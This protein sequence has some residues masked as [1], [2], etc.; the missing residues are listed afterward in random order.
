MRWF[1]FVVSWKR[2]MTRTNWEQRERERERERETW[3]NQ[4]GCHLADLLIW[5]H[6]DQWRRKK[7]KKNEKDQRKTRPFLRPRSRPW[8]TRHRLFSVFYRVLPSF[9]EFYRVFLFARLY[10]VRMGLTVILSVDKRFHRVFFSGLPSFTEFYRVLPSF[11][12][13]FFLLGFTGFEWVLLWFFRLIKGLLHWTGFFTEFY[14]VSFCFTG[15]LLGF[16]G[17]YSV[18]LGF[19][20]FYWVPHGLP[21]FYR[22]LLGL[23]RFYWVLLG[24][25]RYNWVSLGFIE[26]YAVLLS[27]IGYY[28]VLIDLIWVLPGFTFFL[29][30]SGFYY[31]LLGWTTFYWV[32]PY[33]NGF[34][35]FLLG[36]TGFYWVLLI[37]TGFYC[38]LLGFTRFYWVLLGFTGF[39]PFFYW[40]L[41][42]FTGFYCVLLGFTGFYWVF[43]GFFF[44]VLPRFEEKTGR[45]GTGVTT[46]SSNECGPVTNESQSARRR[47][48]RDA[49]VDQW[50]APAR[51]AHGQWG[52]STGR[53]LLSVCVCV[54]V[55][56]CVDTVSDTCSF[57]SAVTLIGSLKPMTS[58][59]TFPSRRVHH[60]ARAAF[61]N[62]GHKGVHLLFCFLFCF[63]LFCFCSPFGTRMYIQPIL[64]GF[65]WASFGFVWCYETFEFH[66]IRITMKHFVS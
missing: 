21:G 30:F 19:S 50:R 49:D 23:T 9:T 44:W 35:R 45:T 38:V 28:W 40:V 66:L 62:L 33:L 60:G 46:R 48:R 6:G 14:W 56:L 3:S 15:F 59:V 31:V 58:S 10:R 5:H 7:K 27:F 29:C 24:F 36:F 47:P 63:V 55:C 43:T 16:T 17:C 2:P 54:C 4:R 12:E 64:T 61:R 26:F 18:L 8:G 1:F 65:Y 37:F 42:I 32:L 41:L 11:T 57:W 39:Y 22:F 20:R 25:T 52:R 51:P 53:Q 34:Y 13:F